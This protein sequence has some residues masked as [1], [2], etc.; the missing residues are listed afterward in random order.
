MN[1]KIRLSFLK[2]LKAKVERNREGEEFL[3][4]D[5]TPKLQCWG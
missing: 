2:Q 3:T 5:M 1:I 4:P